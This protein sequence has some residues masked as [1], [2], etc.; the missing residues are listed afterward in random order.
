MRTLRA[1]DALDEFREYHREYLVYLKKCAA[2]THRS[3]RDNGN[4]HLTTSG[5]GIDVKGELRHAKGDEPVAACT[6]SDVRL[7]YK[8]LK[9]VP[10]RFDPR[11]AFEIV[12]GVAGGGKTTYL[13][14]LYANFDQPVIVTPGRGLRDELRR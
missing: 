3:R 1:R 2:Y 7:Y 4:M 11:A 6:S 13:K 12:A 8:A 5:F 14:N 9:Y 10:W